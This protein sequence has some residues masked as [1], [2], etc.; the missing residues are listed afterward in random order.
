MR[1]RLLFLAILLG[2]LPVRA[3]G[4]TPPATPKPPGAQPPIPAPAAEADEH[5]PL[6]TT[7]GSIDFGVRG[8]HIDGDGARYERY[9]D[10]GDGLFLDRARYNTEKGGWMF[11]LAADHAGRRDQRFAGLAAR[12]GQFKIWGQWDQIPML[13]SRTTRTLFSATSPGE[14]QIDDAIQSQVQAQASYLATAV[15]TARTFDLSSRRHIFDGGAEYVARNGFTIQT[16]VRQTNRDGAIPFGGSFGHGNVVETFAPVEHKLTDVDSSAEYVYG[17]VLVRGGYTGSWFH[18]DVPALTF[19][20]PFRV[21]DTTSGGS[22]GRIALAP[23]NSFIGVNGLLSYKLPYKSR[24]SVYVS[25]GSLRD[26]DAALL[27]FTINTAL[28]VVPLERATTDGHART[29]AVNLTFTSRPTRTVDFDVRFRTYDYDNKT[30]VFRVTQRVGYDNAVST[31]TNPALQET[32][33]FGVKRATFDADVRFNPLQTFS[34]GVGFGHQAEERTHRIFE[35]ITDNTFRLSF[36][37]VGNSRFTLR[38]KYEHTQRRGEGDAAAIAAELIAIGEQGGMRHFDIASRDRDRVTI[39]G[40]V[41]P[42]SSM[43][44]SASLAVGKDD[45]GESVF[46]LRD[47]RHRVYSAGVEYAPDE[48]RSAGVSYSFERYNSLSRSRQASPGVQFDDASRNWATDATDKAHS[49]IGH[50]EFLQ[51]VRNV[52]LTMF[53]DYSRTR[54][55]YRYITG[56]VPDRTLPEETI[57]PTSLPPPT[58]LPPVRSDLGRGNVDV[59]YTLRERWGIGAS[60]GFERYRVK[61]FSLDADALTRLDPAGALL[62]GYQYLPYTAA[63]VF[64][65]TV[66]RF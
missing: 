16:N 59:F 18:N 66:Y 60:V 2:L 35:E 42:L 26:D 54:G 20:N 9:R 28:P 65:R 31:V 56:P 50:A 23:N 30:P 11:D 46:G 21:T 52:D 37:T 48:Y 27:P 55:L 24:A 62:L 4:Q 29:S 8:T 61:D 19:D 25:A 7:Y 41:V 15:Q 32:E 63:T 1:I 43:S 34:A 64:L 12:P 36:D 13:M 47:N 14:L 5:P 49:I 17:D 22:R 51:I 45:Y 33:P 40:A 10:L 38:S 6:P 3:A 58:Q 44:L 53:F 57:V 39:T